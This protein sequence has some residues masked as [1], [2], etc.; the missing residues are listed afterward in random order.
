MSPVQTGVNFV[1]TMTVD[2]QNTDLINYWA[3]EN[4]SAGDQLIFKLERKETYYYGLN[5]YYKETRD[6]T[7]SERQK[8]WQL[9]P[10]VFRMGQPGTPYFMQN[11]KEHAETGNYDCRTHGYWRIAQLMQSRKQCTNKADGAFCWNDDK[12]NLPLSIRYS[13]MILEIIIL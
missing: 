12:N 3:H 4:L 8:C 5:H 11:P 7:F 2:G 6:Q 9:V 1:T 10:S 13:I